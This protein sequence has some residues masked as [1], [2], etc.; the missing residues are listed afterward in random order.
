MARD[1]IPIRP[2][3]ATAVLITPHPSGGKGFGYSQDMR[4]QAMLLKDNAMEN[5]PQSVLLRQNRLLPS[6]ATT[7]R[8]T[9][10]RENLGHYRRFRRTGNK[11]ATV[12]RG[13]DGFLLMYY[14]RVY[15]KATHA[16]IGAFLWNSHSRHLPIPR[17]YDPSQIS[18]AETRYRITRKRASTTANQA[19]EPINVLRRSMFWNCNYPHGIADIA[20]DDMI[21]I[22]EFG[23]TKEGNANRRI[24][25]EVNLEAR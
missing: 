21:D 17:F 4:E 11:R 19:L 12:F 25:K 14:R 3:L 1:P 5:D 8:Y 15:P 22:D 18:R 7:R 6:K 2:A 16:E 24:G 9:Q 20:A 13:L 10:R 23:V